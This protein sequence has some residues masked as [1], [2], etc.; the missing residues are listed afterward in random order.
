MGIQKKYGQK[1]MF[2]AMSN[3]AGDWEDRYPHRHPQGQG[4]HRL[5]FV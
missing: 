2:L 5:R 1:Q 3:Y 4:P